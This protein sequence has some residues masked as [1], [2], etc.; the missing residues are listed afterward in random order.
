MS[1]E[2]SPL[3]MCDLPDL[4]HVALISHEYFAHTRVSKALDLVHPLTHIFERIS[5]RHIIH[6]NDAMRPPVIAAS[7][8][9]E[10]LL[11]GGVPYL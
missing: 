2:L 7:E 5:I 3:I 10:P 9:A 11:S 1:G 8:R 6:Y 4:F